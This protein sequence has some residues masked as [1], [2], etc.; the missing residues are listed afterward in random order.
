MLEVDAFG[1]RPRLF[2]SVTSHLSSICNLPPHMVEN[3]NLCW[4]QS[5]S[6]V[7]FLHASSSLPPANGSIMPPALQDTS[8]KL[9]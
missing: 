8:F 9:R 4:D 6:S 2:A 1:G 5:P 7:G 3:Q